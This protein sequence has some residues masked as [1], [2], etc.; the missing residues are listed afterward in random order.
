[1]QS[2]AMALLCRQASAAPGPLLSLQQL[3]AFVSSIPPVCPTPS[4][5]SWCV[6][7][8]HQNLCCLSLWPSPPGDVA[9]I[10][11]MKDWLFA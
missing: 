10:A 9:V 5:L 11:S 4:S 3:Q 7:Q 6:L 8:L 1:M 2:S